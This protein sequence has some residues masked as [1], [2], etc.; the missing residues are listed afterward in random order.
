MRKPLFLLMASIMVLSSIAGALTV[1]AQ[2]PYEMSLL[3]STLDNPYWI[4]L[5]DGAKKA[6]AEA[7]N[8]N[9]TVL[10]LD[11]EGQIPMQIA[12]MEDRIAKKDAAILIGPQDTKALVPAIE[13]ANKAGVPVIAVDKGAE[14]GEFVSVIMTDNKVA[15]GL[16]ADWMAKQI[17]GKGKVLVLEGI[18]GGQTA[19][20]RKAGAHA[21]L[22]KYPDIQIISLPGDWETAKGQSV[23]EDVLTAN[24]ELAGIVAMNDMMAIGAVTALN[25]RSLN[26][27]VVGCDAIPAALEMIADGRLGAT[28]AQFPGKMGEL[29]IQFALMHLAGKPVPAYV[30]SGTMLVSKDNVLEFQLR[31]KPLKADKKYTFSLLAS[32]LDNPY[33]LTL[34]DG[35]KKRAAELGIE[36]VV[37]ALDKEGQIPMQ[38][39]QMEDRVARP[40]DAILI[41]PQDTKALVPAIEAANAAGVPVVAVDKAA[42]GGKFVSVIMTDN[43]AAGSLGAEWA[44]QQIG[45]KGKVLVLEGVP[46]GQTAEDR[47]A[48]AHAGLKNYADIQIISLPGDWETAKG[49]SVTEDVLTANPDLAA[50][51]AM[52]DMMAIGAQTALAAR[53]TKI[54]VVGCDAIDAALE[55]IEDGRLGATVAQFPGKMGY[56]GVEYAIRSIQGEAVPQ[57]VDSGTMLVTKD[58]VDL[59]ARGIYGR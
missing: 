29:G 43:K 53:G 57:Y 14:G 58:N 52:N 5:I 1:S 10:A 39:G 40:D 16:G 13:E 2:A 28:V 18:P 47:K 55:M 32:T 30:D 15:G 41:G 22:K 23:T 4:A 25:A 21:G 50:V 54:P 19:E 37:L 6:A 56:L 36:L 48:G 45:G 33:W 35:A 3:A 31:N 46:G 11:K 12:Q 42:E 8:V 51:V 27:P 24:P 9:L 38:I 17:G 44:A 59:F 20:D 7:G 34:I 49:Q 26:I